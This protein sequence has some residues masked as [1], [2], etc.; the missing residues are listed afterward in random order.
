M[1]QFIGYKRFMGPKSKK[2]NT[3]CA[4]YRVV[5]SPRSE[6]GQP[7]RQ[8]KLDGIL[9]YEQMKKFYKRMYYLTVIFIIVIYK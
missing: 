9:S 1:I 5:L 4:V 8:V 3:M 6:E 2:R 7:R